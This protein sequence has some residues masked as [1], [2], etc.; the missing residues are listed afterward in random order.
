MH[1]PYSSPVEIN[2]NVQF[3][4]SI[5]VSSRG[6]ELSHGAFKSPTLHICKEQLEEWR[7]KNWNHCKKPSPRKWFWEARSA[8]KKKRMMIRTDYLYW[9]SGAY[10]RLR[11]VK[12][13]HS[14]KDAKVIE[15][16]AGLYNMLINGQDD[17]GC[18]VTEK[19]LIKLHS[20]PH[21]SPT[22]TSADPHNPV[23]MDP[24]RK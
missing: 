20:P 7:A 1:L 24:G 8:K 16:R 17:W 6:A 15:W 9:T 13:L 11:D 2:E 3:S 23:G 19:Q 21:H 10:K 4:F 12:W 22:M 14:G 18:L 5:L